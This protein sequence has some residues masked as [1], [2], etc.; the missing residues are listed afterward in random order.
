VVSQGGNVWYSEVYSLGLARIATDLGKQQ[1]HT[2]RSILVVQEA[3]QL[4][5]LLAE[6]VRSI[7]HTSDDT[8]T[9]CIGHGGGELRTGSHV[10]ARKHDRV[11]DLQ[12]IGDLGS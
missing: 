2:K 3:L 7:A 4:V 8:D 9:T 10:H 5:N 11:V 6:H 1:I 12:K